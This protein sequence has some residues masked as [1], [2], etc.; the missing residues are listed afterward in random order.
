MIYL[1]HPHI[2]I[3]QDVK[4]SKV[5]DVFGIF[6][7]LN[8]QFESVSELGILMAKLHRSGS[9]KQQLSVEV[10]GMTALRTA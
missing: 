10:A 7:A 9:V 6:E 4:L 8:F 2:T 5:D 3:Q 1:K